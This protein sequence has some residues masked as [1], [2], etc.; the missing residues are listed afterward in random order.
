MHG[1][2]SAADADAANGVD[3]LD[4]SGSQLGLDHETGSQRLHLGF[5]TSG[6]NAAGRELGF[7]RLVDTRDLVLTAHEERLVSEWLAYHAS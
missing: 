6:A 3:R 5:S 4:A 2:K 7:K 1:E